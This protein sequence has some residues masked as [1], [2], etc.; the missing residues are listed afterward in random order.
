MIISLIFG[1]ILGVVSVIFIAGNT[2]LVTVTFMSWQFDGSLALVLVLTLLCGIFITLLFLLPSLI[3]DTFYL[4][5]I[6]KQKREVDDELA[7]T[8]IKLSDALTSSQ[9]SKTV[10]VEQATN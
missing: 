4:S 2:S 1:V 6:Q 7:G 5:T 9:V 10:I 8:R 3:R